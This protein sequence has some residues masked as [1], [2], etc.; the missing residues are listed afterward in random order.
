LEVEESRRGKDV[1]ESE[2]EE[3]V[4]ARVRDTEAMPTAKEA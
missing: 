1:K 3:G 4:R 2:E